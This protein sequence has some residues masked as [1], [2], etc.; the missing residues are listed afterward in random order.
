MQ[1][2]GNKAV[3]PHRK[4]GE[5]V[6]QSE[7][8]AMQV[9]G[10]YIGLVEEGRK[11]R[12]TVSLGG[13]TLCT[14]GFIN[15]TLPGW[16]FSGTILFSTLPIFFLSLTLSLSLGLGLALSLVFVSTLLCPVSTSS[17][18]HVD[19]DVRLFRVGGRRSMCSPGDCRTPGDMGERAVGQKDTSLVCFGYPRGPFCCCDAIRCDCDDRYT[20]CGG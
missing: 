12:L 14:K 16:F 8:V 18:I 10:L 20:Y 7:P 17:R 11:I 6:S 9:N 15:S 19:D 1:Y 2:S 13:K 4:R 3:H 5:T